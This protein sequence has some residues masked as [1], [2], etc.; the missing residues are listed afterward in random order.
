MCLPI[1][2]TLEAARDPSFARLPD[3]TGIG[4]PFN[5][6]RAARARLSVDQPTLKFAEQLARVV[7]VSLFPAVFD[8]KRA[9]ILNVLQR[10]ETQMTQCMRVMQEAGALKGEIKSKV[11]LGAAMGGGSGSGTG[12]RTRRSLVRYF[13]TRECGQRWAQSQ[14]QCD[15]LCRYWENYPWG[16]TDASVA[17]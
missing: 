17:F 3:L 4:N 8:G 2:L 15:R 11:V 10:S 9:S 1:A 7:P 6:S 16:G 12:C 14:D 13:L 5:L